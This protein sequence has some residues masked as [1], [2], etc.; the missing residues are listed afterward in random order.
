MDDYSTRFEMIGG[1]E[2]IKDA[3]IMLHTAAEN[4]DALTIDGFYI[5]TQDGYIFKILDNATWQER[6]FWVLKDRRGAWKIYTPVCGLPTSAGSY[7]TRKL[8]IFD[9]LKIS[10]ET[11]NCAFERLFKLLNNY[12]LHPSRFCD[13]YAELVGRYLDSQEG[14]E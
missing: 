3:P 6:D 7:S 4:P 5:E 9:H 1:F 10:E 14:G 2:K 13:V 12:D 11:G 8:A